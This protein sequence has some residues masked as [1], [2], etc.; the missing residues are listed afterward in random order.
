[1]NRIVGKHSLKFGLDMRLYRQSSI[2][3]SNSSG[4]YGFA[5]SGGQG[6]TN[7]PND[8]SSAAPLGQEMASL[9]LGLPTNGNFDLNS[10]QTSQAGYYALFVQDDFRP[11]TGLSLTFGLLSTH[12]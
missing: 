6:W 8:N 2:T 5:L 11:S 1:M 10:A 3:F 4:N 12:Y 7:G 9:L